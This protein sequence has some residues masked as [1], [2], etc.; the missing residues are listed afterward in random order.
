MTIRASAARLRGGAGIGQDLAYAARAMRRSPGFTLATV[1][2][3]ALGVGANTAVFSVL[4]ALLLQPLDAA[5]PHE[6][7][8]AYTSEGRAPRHETDLLGGSSYADYLDL[9][10]SRALAGMA[11]YMPL[12][13]WVE[14]DGAA[15]RVEARV[16]SGDYFTVLGRPPFLGHWPPDASAP[17]VV[18]SH[19]FWMTTLGADPSVIGRPLVVNGRR[20]EI[21]G[22][23]APGF[24]GIELADVGLYLSFETA[25]EMIGRA[26]LMTDR[27]ER[28]V[29][30]LGRLAPGATIESAE[31]S[32]NRV[33]AALAAAH[34]ASNARRTLSLRAATSV[35]PMELM[36]RAVM[37]TASLVFAATLVMLAIAGVNIAAVLLARTV[38][39]RRE[40]ALRLSL[41]ASPLRLVRQL[42]TENV[43]LALAA[44][45][46][47]IVILS[48][49]PELAARLGVP[50]AARP[51]VDLTV[52]AY[53]VATAL[54]AGLVFGLAPAVIGSRTAVGEA[55]RD[56]AAGAPPARARLQRALVAAQIGLSLVLLVV[57]GALLASLDR[58]QRIDPGFRVDRLVVADF[59][60][61]AGGHDRA[62]AHAFAAMAVD[63]LRTLPGVTSVSVAGLVPL[64]SEGARTT[65][66]IPG[67]DGRPGETVD[68][69]A[70]TAGPSYFRTLGIPVLRGRELGPDD[71]D[72]VPRVIVNRTM[73]RRYWGERDPV[74]T[75]VEVGG[76]GGQRAEVIGVAAD[77]RFRSLAEPPRPMYVIQRGAGGGGWKV[78][79]RTGGDPAALLPAVRGAMAR[80]EVPFVLVRLRTMED[81][82]RT[83]LAA[84]RAVSRTLMA[85]GLIAIALAAVGLYGVV[86]YVTAGR[87]REF[88]VR[89]AL[90]ATPWSIRR[91]V[92]GYGMRLALIGGVAGLVLGAAA[93]RAME[94]MLYGSLAFA[95][96]A[97]VVAVVL[98]AVTVAACAV[99]ARRAGTASPSAALRAE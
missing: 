43:L 31:W 37:P 72:T 44:G 67:H 13:A 34:P 85:M 70:V 15:S 55:L 97:V 41:G 24:A 69:A 63:R 53:A 27:G 92:L 10:R 48:S 65:L 39:R 79:I 8:R 17:V 23:T 94:G 74:G 33:M 9:R 73:A 12:G 54:G 86:S 25:R 51:A 28:S 80:N 77:A 89:L 36:G 20:V 61:P 4:N 14:T 42:V 82:V 1:L 52:L 21:G 78:L 18:V 5:R 60:D 26:G 56:A 11:A 99:P 98:G 30:L 6:L 32:L 68:V 90:G 29:R 87:A 64:T 88:G 84:S 40:L 19:R 49:T 91:L 22:V 2:T 7:V 16:V 95:P 3:L 46:V 71:R 93:L 35:V 81:V 47:V 76:A 96:P 38:R 58:Q 59:E 45:A 83:S 62:R 57:G 50:A 75:F 66:H